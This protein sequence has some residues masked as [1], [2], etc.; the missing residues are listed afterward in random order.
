VTQQVVMVAQKFLGARN[1]LR[2]FLQGNLH[3]YCLKT[4]H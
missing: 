1:T 3:G 4:C 2:W